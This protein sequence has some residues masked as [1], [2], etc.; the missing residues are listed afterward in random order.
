LECL[1]FIPPHVTYSSLDTLKTT[2]G[3]TEAANCVSC[4]N[5]FKILQEA[6]MRSLVILFSPY[7]AAAMNGEITSSP[8]NVIFS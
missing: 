6:E 8:V 5:F 7:A 4:W 3:V 2:C 1:D